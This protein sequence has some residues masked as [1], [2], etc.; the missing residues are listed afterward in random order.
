VDD[1]KRLKTDVW[2]QFSIS[3]GA[4][5]STPVK[6]TSKQTDETAPGADASQYGDYIGLTGYSGRF[7]GCWTYRRNGGKEEIWGG[8][9]KIVPDV[10]RDFINKLL[11]DIPTEYPGI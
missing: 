6:V 2:M 5:W 9:K 11:S 8:P 1:L 4:S 3:R 10:L 7:F